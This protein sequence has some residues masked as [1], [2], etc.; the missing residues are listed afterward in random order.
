MAAKILIVDD[1]ATDRLIIQSML[2]GYTVLLACDGLEA[3]QTLEENPDTDIM[4]LDLN[5]PRMNGFQVLDAL[6]SDMRYKSLRTLILTNYDEL[7][8]E[9]KGLQQGAVDYVR[10][11]IHMESLKARIEIHLQLK[12]ALDES[13]RSKSVLLANLQGMAYRCHYDRQWTMQFVSSGCLALTGYHPESLVGNRDLSFQDLIT[14]EYREPLWEEWGRILAERVPFRYEYEIT[15]EDQTR[16]WV[17]EIGRGIYDECGNVEALE[18]IIIDISDRKR[19]ENTLRFNSEHDEW[20]GL[21]NHRYL[22]KVLS[23]D[24]KTKREQNDALISVNLSAMHSLS[25]TYGFQYSQNL[26]KQIAGEMMALCSECC[27]LFN[28]YEYRFVYYV[29]GYRDKEALSAFCDEIARILHP[30]LSIERIGARIGVLELRTANETNVEALLKNLLIT[31]EEATLLGEGENKIRFFDRRMEERIFRKETITRELTQIAAGERPEALLL[32]YQP[33][34]DLKTGRICGFEAL[35]RLRSEQLGLVPPLEFIPIAE[36][37]KHILSL[38]DQIIWMACRFIE[39]LKKQGYDEISVSVNISAIQLLHRDFAGRL[40][41]MI[42][43]LQVRPEQIVLELTESIFSSR[44]SE[45]NR[46]LSELSAYGI[47]CAIDDFG[48]GYSSLSREREL[49]VN[50]L[51]ID[52]SFI[53]KLLYLKPEQTITG[54]IISMAH[55]LGHCVVAE[56]VEQEQ[57]LRYLKERNCDKIQGYLIS[58]PLDEEAAIELLTNEL[59]R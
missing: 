8:N 31:S 48:T 42:Q 16:K 5:M 45:I 14:P 22:E 37:T 46:I 13:E 18:G 56:G 53:D 21:Y 36:A 33:I 26:I 10:K 24:L 51:K 39:K 12:R 30:I 52:K 27:L 50:C 35:A 4:I 7:E 55:R 28:T 25:L 20:T 59:H 32:Q 43:K 23:E 54:D 17:L 47:V 3:L 29:K 6:R 41:R 57:Q 1:S 19:M 44:F 40:L 49:N 9:I 34:L 11:P 15:T 38:G 2:V 58:K